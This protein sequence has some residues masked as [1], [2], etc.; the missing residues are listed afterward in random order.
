MVCSS[1]NP[2]PPTLL[3]SPC[4]AAGGQRASVLEAPLVWG[5]QYCCSCCCLFC[6]SKGR[7]ASYPPASSGGG[8]GCSWRSRGWSG[9]RRGGRD[10]FSLG[11]GLTLFQSHHHHHL[12]IHSS[13]CCRSLKILITASAATSSRGREHDDVLTVRTAGFVPLLAPPLAPRR[14]P[15]SSLDAEAEK[16]GRGSAGQL[17]A[18]SLPGKVATF[19]PWVKSKTC[20]RW[21]SAKIFHQSFKVIQGPAH[22]LVV[23]WL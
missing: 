20:L 8:E 5:E 12:H 17:Q 10:P 14:R 19:H 1:L 7:G 22:I 6:G 2:L 13:Y 21:K 4:L 3:A 11:F 16:P 15:W 23:G 18:W 9:P